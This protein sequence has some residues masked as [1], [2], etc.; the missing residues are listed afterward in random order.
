MGAE[1]E[2]VQG[3]SAREPE[4]TFDFIT[5]SEADASLVLA[6][7]CYNLLHCHLPVASVEL[8]KHIIY[9][10]MYAYIHTYIH[11]YIHTCRQ[12]AASSLRGLKR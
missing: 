10:C 4:G 11:A 7:F 8:Y 2:Q 9:V 5:S 12:R 1:G 6:V 3:I